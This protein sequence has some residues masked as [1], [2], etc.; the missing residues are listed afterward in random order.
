MVRG[1]FLMSG[2]EVSDEEVNTCTDEIVQAIDVD[3]DGDITM[4]GI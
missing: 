2:L 4:V 1:L 3:S